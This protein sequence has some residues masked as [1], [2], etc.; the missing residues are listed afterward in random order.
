MSE[1]GSGSGEWRWRVAVTTHGVIGKL[2]NPSQ[3]AF[4]PGR[5]ISY[6]IL[7]AQELFSGYNRRNLPPRCALKVDLR[8]VYDTLEWD[9]VYVSLRLFGFPERMISWIQECLSTTAYSVSLYGEL[10]DFVKGARSLR[11]G[12]PMSP[13]L[14]VLAMEVL[15]LLLLQRVEQSERF[16]FHWL[17]KD[18]DLL[19]LC[20]VDDL[21]IFCRA[22][23]HSMMLFGTNSN[24]LQNG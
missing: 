18:V 11:Q 2:V 16:Q 17:C 1:C 6:N 22:D 15:H 14:F 19:S 7:L 3:N 8:K 13:Y 21:L 12:D 5:R 20:F 4:V 10:H 23:E 24:Y 9:F